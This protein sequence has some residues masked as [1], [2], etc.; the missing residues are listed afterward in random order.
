M[1]P[2][3][4]R[5]VETGYPADRQLQY[6]RF[7]RFARLTRPRQSDGEEHFTAVDIEDELPTCYDWEEP[8]SDFTELSSAIDE[9]NSDLFTQGLQGAICEQLQIPVQRFGCTYHLF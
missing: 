4:A 7:K 1:L 9:H 5:Y 3:C 2:S 6:R 8:G